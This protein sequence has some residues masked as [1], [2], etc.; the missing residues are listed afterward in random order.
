[1][2]KLLTLVL[3]LSS[4]TSFAVENQI[5]ELDCDK[6]KTALISILDGELSV[7]VFNRRGKR[8]EV[9]MGELSEAIGDEIDGNMTSFTSDEA[10]L[11]ITTGLV[12]KKGLFA[13]PW[14]YDKRTSIHLR[15]KR[16]LFQYHLGCLH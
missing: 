11:M 7:E 12:P 3:F 1:M 16:G 2:K 9:F 8:I 15:D 13:S 14:D 10:G 6:K 4:L 5:M